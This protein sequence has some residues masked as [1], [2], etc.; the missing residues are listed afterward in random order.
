M[1]K[2]SL[3]RGK[4]TLVDNSDYE[5]L[6]QYNWYCKSLGYAARNSRRNK[7]GKQREILMHRVI[8]GLEKSKK[9]CDHINGNRLDNRRTNLRI[10]TPSQN[11]ANVGLSK[12]NSSGFRGV[13]WDP[14]K[15]VKKWRALIVVKGKHKFIGNFLLKEEAAHAYNEAAVKYFGV[16]AKL[17]KI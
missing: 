5:S 12:S 8:L 3:T 10:C 6:N 11:Q 15:F 1:K 9:E 2:I 7:F 16:F 13:G 4:F 14:I 17:N